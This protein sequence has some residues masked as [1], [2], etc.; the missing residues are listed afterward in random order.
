MDIRLARSR[1]GLSACWPR[2]AAKHRCVSAILGAMACLA[3][4]AGCGGTGRVAEPVTALEKI[5]SEIELQP[6]W[7]RQR[8]S[9]AR[10]TEA[11]L[12][13]VVA[14][15]RLYFAEL[16]NRIICLDDETGGLL[17]KIRLDPAS[18]AAE[19]EVR[20][21]AGIG[22]GSG[23]LYL[24]T[25]EGA[26]ISVNPENG[27]LQWRTR[28]TSEVLVPP[29]SQAGIVVVRTSDGKVY[30]LGAEDGRR[31]W[32]YS[33]NMPP[34]SLRGSG[35]PLIALDRVFA[36]FANGKL[37]AM[38]LDD[39]E[40]LWETAVAVPEGRSEL[41]RLVDVDGTP[42]LA[43]GVI[44]AAAYH[45]RLVAVS[46]ISG[47]VLWSRELSSHEDLAVNG[48]VLYMTAD[49]GRVLALE[50]SSGSILWNQ[51]KLVGRNATAPVV[52]AGFVVVADASGYLHWLAPEDGRFVARHRVDNAAITNPPVV[53]NDVLYV[54]S[55]SGTLQAL[56]IASS[57]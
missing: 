11:E 49:D 51:D 39:G 40:V 18:G 31:L 10:D 41:D 33:A 53:V 6:L 20:I 7:Y 30:G 28:L 47:R 3:L 14:E 36:G 25:S 13:P 27:A 48:D 8:Q 46:Q 4:L 29:I 12:V 32:V 54:A 24:G 52:H 9:T 23:R 15:G 2:S 56:R 42:V 45:G 44:Y 17:W 21:S 34:L 37:A 16:S 19:D 5:V 55:R 35:A 57:K 38:S 26:V 43:D 1:R 50:R 22:A